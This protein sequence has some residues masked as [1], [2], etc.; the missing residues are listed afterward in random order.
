MNDISRETAGAPR[1]GAGI[2]PVMRAAVLLVV[3]A[4][5]A[6]SYPPWRF[7]TPS[8]QLDS[9]WQQV[10]AHAA[11]SG[12]QWGRDI[13]FTFGP[14]GFAWNAFY[15][16]PLLGQILFLKSVF[17]AALVVGIVGVLGRTP[18]LWVLP[19]Y[20]VIAFAG[21][22]LG[23]GMFS[24]V[25][26]LAALNY[27]RDPEEPNLRLAV[28]LAM[29]SGVLALTYASSGVLSLALFLLMDV[30]RL[31][32]RR[33]PI[34]VPSM[35]GAALTGF[36]AAGQ[37]LSTLA[38]YLRSSLELV[39]GYP[40]AMSLEGRPSE[41]GVFVV[42]G[43]LSVTLV[44]RSESASLRDPRRRGDS[45][46]LLG[47][48][49][50]YW[51]VM[52]KTGF[53][54]HDLHSVWSWSA[55][56]I[57]LAA[58]LAIRGVVRASQPLA[59]AMFGVAV[60][61]CCVEAMLV[62]GGDRVSFIGMQAQ[63]VFADTPAGAVAEARQVFL[64][65]GAWRK[66]MQ[67]RRD[68]ARAAVSAAYG[69]LRMP[70]TVDM[71]GHSQGAL[72]MQDVDLRPSPVFQDF[73]AYTPWLMELN[74]AHLRGPRAAGT[75][76]LSTEAVDNRY[77]MMDRG[78]AVLELLAHYRPERVAAGFLVLRRR[79]A[80]LD[81]TLTAAGDQAATLGQWIEV[82]A[83]D[84]PVMLNVEIRPNALGLLAKL[85][86]R[87]PHVGLTVRLADGTERNHRVVPAFAREGM[88]LS[89]Y[90]DGIVS[91]AAMATGVSE[92][93]SGNR[94][95]AMKIDTV[96]P[97]G[98]AFLD[99][100]LHVRL[101]SIRMP[102]V[103]RPPAGTE[104]HRI[105]ERLLTVNRMANAVV[106]RNPLL[107]AQETLLLAHPPVAA[108]LP[109][110]SAHQLQ[111]TYG[112]SDGAWKDGRATDGVCFRIFATGSTGE[113]IKLHER[114]LRPVE[115]AEDRGEHRITLPLSIDNPGALVFETDCG[116]NCSWDWAYWKD[117]DV[118]P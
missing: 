46:L 69:E 97:E 94:V 52:F 33:V 58:Y 93:T 45:V 36:V 35:L 116:G 91:Y 30:S 12:W 47:C 8:A 103:D 27:F 64:D 32:R 34:F 104:Q 48:M 56:A 100:S 43:L 28:P 118:A 51:F 67:E 4:H 73:A 19:L 55:L 89:P 10:V 2:A 50:I 39:A 25:P 78:N 23:P 99:N 87:L 113:R 5:L 80:P 59:I 38:G 40:D 65:T 60:A 11:V 20:A 105:L 77:P 53:V 81:V 1:H 98:R 18:T 101:S 31:R 112:V 62:R 42:L 49:A 111:T 14:L 22:M 84:A 3:A 92:A 76:L 68:S 66:S 72:L 57:G 71:M 90:V 26:L 13:A 107:R 63:R 86:F 108:S 102:A 88:L 110:S 79:D 95:V 7:G 54:R 70:G 41:L 96:K 85:A 115:R 29:I 109:V 17:V 15:M 83:S 117:I 16:E 114:C 9:S 44:V 6:L 37:S 21:S 61:S 75:I 82:G 106:P 24:I 74:R